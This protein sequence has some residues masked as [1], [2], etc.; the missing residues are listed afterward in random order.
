MTV[1]EVQIS[2]QGREGPRGQ[3]R[4]HI[5]QQRAHMEKVDGEQTARVSLLTTLLAQGY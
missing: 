1:R 3:H 5:R 4:A 2:T